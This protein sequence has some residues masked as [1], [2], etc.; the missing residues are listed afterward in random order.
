MS[1]ATIFLSLQLGTLDRNTA[2]FIYALKF[3]LSLI[4]EASYWPGPG[5]SLLGKSFSLVLL[6]SKTFLGIL[7]EIKSATL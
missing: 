1:D 4:Y 6:G 2:E 3:F 5:L 7:L